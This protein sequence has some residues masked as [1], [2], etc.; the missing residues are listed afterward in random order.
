MSALLLVLYV[1]PA[2]IG[3]VMINAATPMAWQ[4]DWPAYFAGLK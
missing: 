1:W 4:I 3:Q 2:L